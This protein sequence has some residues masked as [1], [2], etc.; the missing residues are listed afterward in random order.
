MTLETDYVI[1]KELV[2][3]RKEHDELKGQIM[4][5]EEGEW[6]INFS[7]CKRMQKVLKNNGFNILYT[8]Q[9]LP[10]FIKIFNTA[11]KEMFMGISQGSIGIEKVVYLCIYFK[12]MMFFRMQNLLSYQ[13]YEAERVI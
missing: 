3:M 4:K 5:E 7:T 13:T 6:E 2:E 11:Y 1:L 9:G 12:E 10:E 8:A